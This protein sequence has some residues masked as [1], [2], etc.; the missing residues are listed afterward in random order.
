MVKK[1]L[2][3]VTFLII[4]IIFCFSIL[5]GHTITSTGAFTYRFPIQI[6]AGTAGMNPELSLVYNSSGGNGIVGM[7][8][9]IGG[10]SVITRDTSYPIYFDD[11]DHYLYNGEKLI[12]DENG[13]YHTR[14]E[15]Y[16]RI[17]A[18]NLNS[19]YAHWIITLKDGTK[20]YF[21]YDFDEEFPPFPPDEAHDGHIPAVDKNGV[22]RL[23]A[24]RKVKD[25][26]GNYYLID[27]YC[28]EEG[29]WYAPKKITYTL[30][31]RYP[32]PKT[33]TAE[34]VLQQDVPIDS[35]ERYIPSRVVSG[36]KIEWILVKAD[37]SIIRKYRFTYEI[38][39]L[40]KKRRLIKITEYGKDDH[41]LPPFQFRY[42]DKTDQI[43]L[44]HIW[45]GKFDHYEGK[46]QFLPIDFNG[47]GKRDILELY[48]RSG[49]TYARLWKSTGDQFEIQH[50]QFFEGWGDQDLFLILDFNGDQ[51]E[52]VV[53]IRVKHGDQKVRLWKSNGNS[54]SIINDQCLSGYGAEDKFLPIDVNGDG[55]DDL[56]EIMRHGKKYDHR[57]YL[58]NG[59]AFNT[60]PT[61]EMGGYNITDR[62]IPLDVNGDRRRDIVEIYNS[63]GHYACARVWA[64]NGKRFERSEDFS[65]GGYNE[66]DQFHPMDINGDGKGDI[67]EIYPSGKSAM[68]RTWISDGCTLYRS[69]LDEVLCD[70]GSIGRIHTGDL[71]GD[72]R[73][74]FIIAHVDVQDPYNK[75]PSQFKIST[76]LSLGTVFE[77]KYDGNENTPLYDLITFLIDVD[78]DGRADIFHLGRENDVAQTLTAS[79]Y[80]TA[81]EHPDLLSTIRNGSGG[82]VKITYLPSLLVQGAIDPSNSTYPIVACKEPRQIVTKI[83][84]QDGL[85]NEFEKS[86]S[87]HNAKKYL[88]LPWGQ[89]DMGFQCIEKIDDFTGFCEKTYY[90]QYDRYFDHLVDVKEIHDEYG[91][92]YKRVSYSYDQFDR[93]E[94]TQYPEIKFIYRSRIQQS[95][96]DGTGCSV[97]YVI[98]YKYDF[99][100]GEII[101][102]NN[103]GD[104]RTTDDNVK[105]ETSYAFNAKKNIVAPKQITRLS[106]DIEGFQEVKSSEEYYFYDDLSFGN[107]E[108]GLL[109]TVKKRVHR[110]ENNFVI[111]KYEY[112][113]YGNKINY[114]DGRAN[115]G[116]Y[117]SEFNGYTEQ[118]IYDTEYKTHRIKKINALDGQE[119]IQF[120]SMTDGG[121]IP[122]DP[123]TADL[124]IK[125]DCNNQEWQTRNDEFG[126]E[127]VTVF[128]EDTIENP[129]RKKIYSEAV[130]EGGFISFPKQIETQY[131]ENSEG[132]TYTIVLYFDG[133][134]RISKEIREGE[135]SRIAVDYLYNSN[136]H[137]VKKSIPYEMNQTNNPHYT[138]MVYDPLDRIIRIIN[139]DESYREIVYDKDI[140]VHIDENGN[141][142][143]VEIVGNTRRE[144]T[145]LL[146]DVITKTAADGIRVYS[147][148]EG[149]NDVVFL[150][151]MDMLKRRTTIT[152]PNLGTWSM[153]YDANGNV[154]YKTDAKNSAIEFQ[155]DELNRIR[156]KIYPDLSITEY[157]YDLQNNHGYS[158]G[159]LCR[160]N[161]ASGGSES[162]KY[163]ER[164]RVISKTRIIDGVEKTMHYEYDSMD[165][166]I[167]QIYPEPDKEVVTYTY[168]EGGDLN[169]IFGNYN[170]V[171]DV[172]YT[173]NNKVGYILFGNNIGMKYDYY[174]NYGEYDPSA[175]SYHS[176][177]LRRIYSDQADVFDI[178]Y[179][180]DRVGN[181]IWKF[182][183]CK[184]YYSEYYTYDQLNRL[185][186]ANSSM[187]GFKEYKYDLLNNLT[188]KDNN[189][190][191]YGDTKPHSVIDDGKCTYEYD[192]NGNLVEIC[193]GI[194]S[195]TITYDYDN[196]MTSI[197]NNRFYKYDAHLQ[198]IMKYEDGIKTLYFFPEYEEEYKDW[199]SDLA[200]NKYYFLNGMR[201]AKWSSSDGLVF[202]HTDHL[203]TSLRITDSSGSVIKYFKYDPFGEEIVGATGTYP[204]YFT[205]DS[206]ASIRDGEEYIA[207]YKID[208]SGEICI[209]NNVEIS[210]IAG[211]KIVLKPG[212]CV[213]E[214][215]T[216]HFQI[217]SSILEQNSK[218]EIKYR[219][220]GKECEKNG[221]YYY[222]A[223]YYDPMLGKFLSPDTF[224]DDLNRYAYCCNN[225][226]KYIDPS[227][228]SPIPMTS[229]IVNSTWGN[230]DDIGVG[231]TTRTSG[232]KE[233]RNRKKINITK[234]KS[235][236][237]GED[238]FTSDDFFNQE[239]IDFI[240][241]ASFQKQINI[242]L[243]RINKRTNRYKNN[244]SKY[245]KRL[246]A[247]ALN[248]LVSV[249]EIGIETG[250][251]PKVINEG[252]K[253]GATGLSVGISLYDVG[254]LV[255]DVNYD[256]FDKDDYS[257]VYNI[258]MD[259][260]SIAAPEIG[261]PAAPLTVIAKY[262]VNTLAKYIAIMESKLSNPHNMNYFINKMIGGPNIISGWHY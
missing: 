259:V 103:L 51:K 43:L 124:I 13:R 204:D 97:D 108:N 157:I 192:N 20:M 14:R 145:Y 112:D 58:S 50:T 87:Y 137:I 244:P 247:I 117:N 139:P 93:V 142:R 122:C 203:G 26:N 230:G 59:D 134:G 126:R 64:S 83:S 41:A 183:N 119:K 1:N 71:N 226:V 235:S 39:P 250:K 155:Y 28:D 211:D 238:E 79:I 109:T 77:K 168:N 42:S 174:D 191:Y 194:S 98:E 185:I 199:S 261:L 161:Y 120:F 228:H 90:N 181:I 55:R 172:N 162:Y 21:G 125:I 30:N 160:I 196:M 23:W 80:M 62:F 253:Y 262:E 173:S 221:L 208:T 100:T 36:R 158:M 5:H 232:E 205:I 111:T 241:D 73:E 9:A 102:Q 234:E 200:V 27:Y 94:N 184:M 219:Y 35:C 229:I 40:T 149:G 69:G 150:T 85:G 6:P 19:P 202:F 154:R 225:P 12:L 251:L 29:G 182:D 22:A 165:R 245:N 105:V 48:P 49:E 78:G 132:D 86:F 255:R 186:Y 248:S 231:Y 91:N 222:G 127:I 113:Q 17:E 16:L 198:R 252:L 8:W 175:R 88:D 153:E 193:D 60:Q 170:Y 67:L 3:L 138:E 56:V 11:R 187:Y 206:E 218:A 128:P 159:R 246:L 148:N 215:N 66:S 123:F 151:K 258:A 33:R 130:V 95:I 131:K 47:D 133:F 213:S 81:N 220:T 223:R 74:D 164:G 135:F 260:V 256:G 114:K 243:K 92:L 227:G 212:F 25:A 10:L 171:E 72:K 18:H 207:R 2:P 121:K 217:D 188:F 144:K 152:D 237:N 24:L 4:K 156:K 177:R 53:E 240:K 179:E 209:G 118:Y 249:I 167:K 46:N 210:L 143:K 68:L 45:T 233:N 147:Y 107:I 116:E 224:L 76:W 75:K 195:N 169:S 57:V 136:G 115:N 38:S 99:V 106:Y 242:I 163:D 197:A 70:W 31:D 32:L 110:N 37:G 141:E 34:F 104:M 236:I 129:T 7:G 176:Y 101:Q 180:Y 254:S 44:D 216:V 63:G 146:S 52:D 61:Y 84:F 214:N 257:N 140:T 96:F 189:V 166:V 15:K 190:F 201:I 54:F 178:S 82:I 89:V 239:F 65:F